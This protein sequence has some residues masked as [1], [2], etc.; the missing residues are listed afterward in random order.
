M[1]LWTFACEEPFHKYLMPSLNSAIAITERVHKTV[2]T[3]H[4]WRC[5]MESLNIL[6]PLL[7]LP[8]DPQSTTSSSCTR[9]PLQFVSTTSIFI[10]IIPSNC[11]NPGLLLLLLLGSWLPLANDPWQRKY[12]KLCT[13]HLSAYQPTSQPASRLHSTSS[14]TL[15]FAVFLPVLVHENRCSSSQLPVQQFC[16]MNKIWSHS[17]SVSS[18]P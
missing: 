1:T 9:R 14:A 5:E 11:N 18:Y 6:E 8:A 2:P 10:V 17:W 13:T 3:H 12:Y 7:L 15:P 16:D 4:G